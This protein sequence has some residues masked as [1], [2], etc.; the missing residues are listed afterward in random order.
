M[1]MNELLRLFWN[2]T[3][4]CAIGVM[5]ALYK[6]CALESSTRDAFA[7][8]ARLCLCVPRSI[9]PLLSWKYGSVI[10]SLS[11]VFP[12]DHRP[13]WDMNP[14]WF[15]ARLPLIIPATVQDYTQWENNCSWISNNCAGIRSFSTS[16]EAAHSFQPT[17]TH[18]EKIQPSHNPLI[19]VV[20]LDIWHLLTGLVNSCCRHGAFSNHP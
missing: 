17:H 4:I 16:E 18:T 15:G 6:L 1:D 14:V 12:W 10:C 19:H 20:W 2:I 7:V 13:P 11:A 9:N 5:Q 3:H 8:S